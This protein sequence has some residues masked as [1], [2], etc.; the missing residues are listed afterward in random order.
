MTL[1]QRYA[2]AERKLDVARSRGIR[3]APSVLIGV[4][5][6]L[7]LAVG[8]TAVIDLRR[9][10]S[11]RGAALAWTEAAVFG[12]CPAYLSLSRP[13]DPLSERRTD[14][15]LC[16]DLRRATAK[17]RTNANRIELLVGPAD[18]RD[19]TATVVVEVRGPD[20]TATGRLSLVR[21]GAHWLV[22]R[23]G[24]ACTGVGCA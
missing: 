10:Q 22:L 13:V 9:L 16:R 23:D 7:V 18:E 20:G 6:A 5:A 8:V 3:R 11:P 14:D 19:R 2:A 12:N 24:Q 1:E 4:T 21:R 15:E 17:A